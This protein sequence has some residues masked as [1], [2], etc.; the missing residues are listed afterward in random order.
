MDRRLFISAGSGALIAAAYGS[1]RGAE[2]ATRPLRILI[3]GGTAFLGIHMTQLALA[4][5]HTVTLFNRGRTNRELFPQVEK[6]HGDRDG[7]LDALKGRTWDA[8]VDDSGYVPRHV[9]LSA[10]LLGPSI[11]QYLYVSSISAYASF[12]QPDEERSPLGR[13]SDE[14]IEKVDENTY[15]P[16]KALCEKAAETAL[17]GRVTI[18]RPG[19]IVGPND[20]TDRFTYWPARAARGGEMLVPGKPSDRIQFIDVRDVARFNIDVLEQRVLGTFNLVSPP[21]RFTMGE[22]INACIAGANDVVHPRPVPTA[23]WI[24]VKFLKAHD[25]AFP[26]DIPIWAPASGDTAAFAET[27][28]TRALRAGMHITPIERTVRD[29]LVWHLARP[30]SEQLQLK[31]GLTAA[32]EQ[33]ILAAWNRSTAGQR[34]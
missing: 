22:L 20:P 8:V 23:A 17:P 29:T 28:A 14:S 30:Q 31:A 9:R 6:L 16:L 2:P 33:E 19:Y 24:P 21:G 26:D 1:A 25:P 18:V 11:R 10:E 7:K 5:G 13:L 32:R 27:S 34:A 4:R 15:G 12:K 3:L